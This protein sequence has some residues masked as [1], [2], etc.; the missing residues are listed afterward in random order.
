MLGWLRSTASASD[1][2][3]LLQSASRMPCRCRSSSS[4]WKSTNSLPGHC[5]PSAMPAGAVLT[6]H[7]APERVV[8]VEHDALG[9]LAHRGEGEAD[10]ALRH[11]RHQRVRPG[12]VSAVVGAPVEGL[13]PADLGDDVRQGEQEG[14]IAERQPEPEML[15]GVRDGVGEGPLAPEGVD[16]FGAPAREDE[17]VHHH[18]ARSRPD[19]TRPGRRTAASAVR[20]TTGSLLSGGVSAHRWF[21]STSPSMARKVTCGR[22]R[23]RPEPGVEQL[24][25][26]LAVGGDVQCRATGP[27]APLRPAAPERRDRA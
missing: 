7:S 16:A 27:P 12:H 9:R 15:V 26:V 24:R 10:V 23:Y 13:S 8:E 25:Q 20:P 21:H 11:G 2:L 19:R 4:R 14:V 1:S 3:F 17:V 22:N 18:D 6:Q 5:G